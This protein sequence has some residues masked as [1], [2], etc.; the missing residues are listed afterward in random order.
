M[1]LK[2]AITACLPISR[3]A[4]DSV[5]G[6]VVRTNGRAVV[7]GAEYQACGERHE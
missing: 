5:Q 6:R 4:G 3:W 2:T 1:A 7:H